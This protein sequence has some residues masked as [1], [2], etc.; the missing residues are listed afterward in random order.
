MS[1]KTKNNFILLDGRENITLDQT[2]CD[3]FQMQSNNDYRKVS[4][5]SLLK[6]EILKEFRV[7]NNDTGIKLG[8]YKFSFSKDYSDK[9]T[10][11][12]CYQKTYWSGWNS[13][14]FESYKRQRAEDYFFVVGEFSESMD[15]E[16]KYHIIHFKREKLDEFLNKK[17]LAANGVYYFYFSMEKE[18]E[19]N[20][21]LKNDFSSLEGTWKNGRN[22]KLVILGNRI[23]NRNHKII[24]PNKEEIR[25]LPFLYVRGMFVGGY[26]MGLL[27]KNK[28][29]SDFIDNSNIKRPRLVLGQNIKEYSEDEYFYRD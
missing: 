9:E 16:K 1:F 18:L 28:S 29:L 4:E 20:Q 24:A 7:K 13:F 5:K 22:E 6:E 17:E 25:G 3:Y 12:K 26:A 21:I 10:Q 14:S 27:P 2:Q 15:E 8:D 11:L 19:I 23:T